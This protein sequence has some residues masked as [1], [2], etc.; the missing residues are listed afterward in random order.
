MEWADIDAGR[1][2]LNNLRIGA[3]DL[4]PPKNRDGGI[5]FMARTPPGN[6]QLNSGDFPPPPGDRSLL[7][8]VES[9][10]QLL[11]PNLCKSNFKNTGSILYLKILVVS[12]QFRPRLSPNHYKVGKVFLG[13]S[14][15]KYRPIKGS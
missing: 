3:T 12:V 11:C 9:H 14:I 13:F 10:I 2:V 15:C 6:W 5:Y 1:T 8:S 4:H 7:V